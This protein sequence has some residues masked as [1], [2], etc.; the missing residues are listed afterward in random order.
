LYR[1]SGRHRKECLALTSSSTLAQV[2]FHAESWWIIPKVVHYRTG[3]QV[4]VLGKEGRP[5]CQGHEAR[6]VSSTR[7]LSGEMEYTVL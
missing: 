1:T 4:Q 6:V 7:H 5:E 3:E 2:L